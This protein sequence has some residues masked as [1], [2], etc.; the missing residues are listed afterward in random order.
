MN[1]EPK[2]LCPCMMH[3][4]KIIVINIYYLLGTSIM[5]KMRS[6]ENC[7]RFPL[8][9]VAGWRICLERIGRW[10][11]RTRRLSGNSIVDNLDN[12]YLVPHPVL[13]Q[14]HLWCFSKR[15]P[16]SV[17]TGKRCCING[18]VISIL[19]S[20][21]AAGLMS[22]AKFGMTVREVPLASGKL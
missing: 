19:I 5:K 14:C 12:I 8:S 6:S 22:W 17:L 7:F 10:M 20:V 1:N 9:F 4:K 13:P 15:K 11:T 3:D 21:S 2:Y 18:S 16:W